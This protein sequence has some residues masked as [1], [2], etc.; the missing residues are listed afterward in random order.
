MFHRNQL[1]VKLGFTKVAT[2]SGATPGG[3]ARQLPE[4]QELY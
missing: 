3:S 4:Q 1:G 2:H